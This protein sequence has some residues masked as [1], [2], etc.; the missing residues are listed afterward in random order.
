MFNIIIPLLIFHIPYYFHYYFILIYLWPRLRES[1]Y[2]IS[3]INKSR[4]GTY[5]EGGRGSFSGVIV[6]IFY[7][8]HILWLFLHI[9]LFF[10]HILSSFPHIMQIF[11]AD[12]I[13]TK[14]VDLSDKDE[15]FYSFTIKEKLVSGWFYSFSFKNY[16][17]NKCFGCRIIF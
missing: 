10:P 11:F 13:F 2:Y 7:E 14:C 6:K 12:F 16:F 1:L 17:E 3:I 8:Y 5:W 4:I 15:Y 9:F